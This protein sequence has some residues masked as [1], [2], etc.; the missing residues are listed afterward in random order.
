MRPVTDPDILNQ[1]EGGSAGPKPVTDPALLAQLEGGASPL[2]PRAARPGATRSW[3]PSTPL[4]TRSDLIGGYDPATRTVRPG[5]PE[6]AA[7][8]AA[9]SLLFNLPGLAHEAATGQS[10]TPPAEGRL[11]QGGEAL[12]SLYGFLKGPAALAE[13]GFSK[14]A[15]SFFKPAQTALG[16]VGKRVVRG[17]A[18]LGLAS[19]ATEQGGLA[20]GDWLGNLTSRGKALASGAGMGAAFGG[21]N[22]VNIPNAPRLAQ[23][24]RLGLAQVYRGAAHGEHPLDERDFVQKVFDA[25][26]DAYFTRHGQNPREIAA[27]LKEYHAT[28]EA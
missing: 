9:N 26:L 4:V 1:L 14:L 23:A 2:P 19:A 15:P 20:E 11:G 27:L 22:L 3:E 10:F 28:P 24:I 21:I 6:R 16:E 17:A 13:R 25:G 18:T 12:G 8:S 7:L 5:L